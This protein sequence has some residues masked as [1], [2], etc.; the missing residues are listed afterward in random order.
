M[1]FNFC[2]CCLPNFPSR[3]KGVWYTY[4]MAL[5]R[6]FR[7][8]LLIFSPSP[9]L[10]TIWFILCSA[11]LLI[12]ELAFLMIPG[13]TLPSWLTVSLPA[14]AKS[15]LFKKPPDL[16]PFFDIFCDFLFFAVAVSCLTSISLL[17]SCTKNPKG[18]FFYVTIVSVRDLF[19][20]PVQICC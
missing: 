12:S 13:A 5:L 11:M 3:R 8:T 6:M 17:G 2:S 9:L 20:I 19:K 14:Q 18:L 15:Y 7:S 1:F 16:A 10:L 4:S